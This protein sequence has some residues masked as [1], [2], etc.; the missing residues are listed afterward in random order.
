MFFGNVVVMPLW[1]QQHVGYTAT[2]AGLVTAPIGFLVLLLS[3]L[4]ERQPARLA[5]GARQGGTE[6]IG[7]PPLRKTLGPLDQPFPSSPRTRATSWSTVFSIA[8]KPSFG[9]DTV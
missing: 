2:W 1:L 4:A 9:T 5:S 6:A 7:G 8:G 3:P